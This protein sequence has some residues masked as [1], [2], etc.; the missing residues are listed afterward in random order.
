M[1]EVELE[2]IPLPVDTKK[3]RLRKTDPAPVSDYDPDDIATVDE[4]VAAFWE[5]HPLGAIASTVEYFA[6]ADGRLSWIG[7]ARVWKGERFE[8]VDHPDSTGS[9]LRVED[10][11]SQYPAFETAE[12]V[13]I[14]RALRFLGI[15]PNRETPNEDTPEEA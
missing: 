15:R 14:G 11:D 3:S 9:A 8:S 7:T 1:A 2:E 12:S 10:L 13:A 6:H 4:K 5:Q